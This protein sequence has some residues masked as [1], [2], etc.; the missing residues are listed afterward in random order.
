MAKIKNHI[1]ETFDA[2]IEATQFGAAMSDKYVLTCRELQALREQKPVKDAYID[3]FGISVGKS[4]IASE[5]E[6][7]ASWKPLYAAPVPSSE[8]WKLDVDAIMEQAQVFASAWSLVGG[9][10]D[11]GDGMENA[12]Q[13][14]VNLRTML[15]AA[16]KEQS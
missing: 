7:P 14:K 9:M 11:F 3:E 16:P 2:L 15:E 6:I 10:F 12:E 5:R 1:Q 4:F 8:G 13:E